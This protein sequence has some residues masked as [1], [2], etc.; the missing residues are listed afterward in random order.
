MAVVPSSH[1]TEENTQGKVGDTVITPQV[2]GRHGV[3]P[4]GSKMAGLGGGE[5][6]GPPAAPLQDWGKQALLLSS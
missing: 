4:T 6:P 2:G 5:P 3:A 1:F